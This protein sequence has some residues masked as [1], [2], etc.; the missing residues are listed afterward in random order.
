MLLE[1]YSFED[2]GNRPVTST[3]V[4]LDVT[5]RVAAEIYCNIGKKCM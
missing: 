4:I 2:G 1:V 5:P 3:L